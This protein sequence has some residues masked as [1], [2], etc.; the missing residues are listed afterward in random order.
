MKLQHHL[1]ATLVVLSST[2]VA[3]TPAWAASPPA[4]QTVWVAQDVTRSAGYTL[5][6]VTLSNTGRI[7]SQKRVVPPLGSL[8]AFR[9]IPLSQAIAK[10][11]AYAI[12][13]A[14]TPL[15]QQLDQLH[16]GLFHQLNP[17]MN[18]IS[19]TPA[20]LAHTAAQANSTEYIQGQF[21][22]YNAEIDWRVYYSN[23][24]Y[25]SVQV[26]GYRVW[27]ANGSGSAWQDDM[28]WDGYGYTWSP[29][30]LIPVSSAG[31]QFIAWNGLWNGE[32]GYTFTT[33]VTGSNFWGTTYSGYTTIS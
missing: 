21:A 27:Q 15:A 5:D 8:V 7:I 19:T 2:T 18:S 30:P 1:M 23:G 17:G 33:D 32:S 13:S 28:N 22:A 16:A 6:Y 20:P 9:Q 3:S 25:N 31:S 12:P 29:A 24:V 11:L 10:G 4:S 26:S 14:S